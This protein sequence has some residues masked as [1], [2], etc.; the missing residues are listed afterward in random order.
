MVSLNTYD[1]W[2]AMKY[3]NIPNSVCP[4][5]YHVFGMSDIRDEGFLNIHYKEIALYEK[6]GDK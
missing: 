1:R 6:N 3:S 5:T 2:L 4:F